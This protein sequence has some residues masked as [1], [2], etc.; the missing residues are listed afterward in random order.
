MSFLLVLLLLGAL[1]ALAG[2]PHSTVSVSR[3]TQVP[4]LPTS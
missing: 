3:H 2:W 1:S 4:C